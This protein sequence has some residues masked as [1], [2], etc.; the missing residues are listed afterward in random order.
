MT[1]TGQ[2]MKSVKEAAD[3]GTFDP[4][5]Q[6]LDHIVTEVMRM[7]QVE[8]TIVPVI[9]IPSTA[10]WVTGDDIR[11]GQVVSNLV[12]NAM[13]ASEGQSVRVL[14]ISSLATDGNFVEVRIED[15]GP[16]ISEEMKGK[17]FSPF[18]STK[19]G[20]AGVGLSICRAIIEQHHGRIWAE[21]LPIGSAFC[22]TVPSCKRVLS[23]RRSRPRPQAGRSS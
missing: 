23:H 17:L 10:S 22:F 5:P 14:R 20:G 4:C 1:R 16:G 6:D 7:F 19:A 2:V 9:D 21:A 8:A 15:N 12:R 11:L 18:A 13:E 3:G